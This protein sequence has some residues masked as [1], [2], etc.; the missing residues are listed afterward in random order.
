MRAVFVTARLLALRGC[1]VGPVETTPK[2]G[3]ISGPAAQPSVLTTPL[4]GTNPRFGRTLLQ[5][6]L[7]GAS[8]FCLGLIRLPGGGG[9]V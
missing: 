6:I 1:S 5:F 9:D 2:V 3:Q 8:P 4:H 7:C